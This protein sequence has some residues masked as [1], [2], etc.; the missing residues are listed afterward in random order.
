MLDHASR[1]GAL[2]ASIAV[3]LLTAGCGGGSGIPAASGGSSS[4]QGS[5]TQAPTISG[6][7]PTTAT[8]AQAYKFQPST[9]NPSGGTLTFSASN[10]P[11]W[12]SIDSA[13]GLLHGTPAAADVGTDSA[14]SITVSDGSSK[15]SLTP[16]SIVVNQMANGS[17]IL[18]WTAP[19][20]NTDGSALSSLASYKI[21]YGQS[22]ANLD[23]SVTV[24][25]PSVTQYQIDN[26]QSGTWYFSVVAINSTGTE[27]SPTNVASVTI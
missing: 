27:S 11:P 9:S 20:Q 3:A 23:Q 22:A 18:S 5:V 15:S 13:T 21:L 17:A 10:L 19:T 16:F 2:A 25:N 26:L 12:L 14:I 4:S 24:N 8:V 6:Q 7:P 1:L